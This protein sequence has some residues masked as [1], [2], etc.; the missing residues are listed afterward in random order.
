M[1]A[2]AL[3]APRWM[4]GCRISVTPLPVIGPNALA[5]GITCARSSSAIA[6]A[7]TRA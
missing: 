6:P 7:P 3:R 5:I 1:R 2:A 4:N